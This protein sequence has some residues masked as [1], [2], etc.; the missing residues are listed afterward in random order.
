MSNA[1]IRPR[2][3]EDVLPVS[4]N[5]VGILLSFSGCKEGSNDVVSD[6]VDQVL[7]RGQHS[8]PESENILKTKR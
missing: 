5:C 2:E 1:T 8:I 7:A 4:S 6:R 3:M